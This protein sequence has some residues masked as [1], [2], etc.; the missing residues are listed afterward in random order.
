MSENQPLVAYPLSVV[1][2]DLYARFGPWPICRALLAA[3]WKGTGRSNRVADLSNHLRRDVG[4]VERDEIFI[5][6]RLRL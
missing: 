5:P 6:P 1:I 2:D 3:A 4:L